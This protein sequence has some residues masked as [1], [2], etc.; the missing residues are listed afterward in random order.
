MI[1]LTYSLPAGAAALVGSCAL[2][3]SAQPSTPAAPPPPPAANAAGTSATYTGTIT[4]FNYGPDGRVEGFVLSPNLLVSVPPDWAA[5]FET[6]AKPGDSVRVTGFAMPAA[7]TGSTAMRSVRAET[8]SLGGKT[9]THTAPMAPAPYTGSG[10]IRQLNY[11]P[12]GEVNGFVLQNGIIARTSPVGDSPLSVLKPGAT[13][14]LA[15]MA[16]TT[17]SGRTV[18]QVQSIT[19]NGQTI[20]MMAQV[21]PPPPAPGRPPRALP[22][23]AGGPVGAAAPP[24][25]PNP[26]AAPPAPP[27]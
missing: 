24:P 6:S 13:I 22:P 15:G 8:L 11:G 20:A 25:P 10:V 26:P 21:P 2:L 12:R 16:R 7:N 9:Y 18:V 3:L 17:P 1:R 19:A 14:S 23:R 4:Q 5:Q 27:Q